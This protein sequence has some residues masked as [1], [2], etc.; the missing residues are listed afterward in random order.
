MTADATGA[1]RHAPCVLDAT[2]ERSRLGAFAA[3]VGTV[4]VHATLV[5]LSIAA[6]STSIERASRAPA[7]VGEMIEVEIPQPEQPAP[8]PQV[9]E[10]A[11]AP[12][13]REQRTAPTPPAP[14]E[15]T[16][17]APPPEAAQAGE[18]LT[19]EPE[20]EVIDFGDSFVIGQGASYAGGTTEAGGT[21]AVAVRDANARA[22][23]TPGGTG[24]DVGADLS[25]PARMAGSGVWD[26]C[27]FPEEADD[28]GI[29]SATVALRVEIDAD[30][31]VLSADVTRDPGD[32]FGREAKRC[33][34]AARFVP[35]LDRSGRPTRSSHA[36]TI[37]FVRR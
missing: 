18:V 20:P 16:P 25:R 11:V 12:T 24:T 30:G 6:A 15:A 23:G 22:G 8:P 35:A 3:A 1:G 26:H 2:P 13:P 36:L 10:T 29:D 27:P 4:A 7:L 37:R 5:G 32:G 21:S 31:R 28:L 19:A 34:R 17:A 33:A 14:D 9:P